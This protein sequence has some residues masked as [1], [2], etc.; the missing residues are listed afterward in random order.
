MESTIASPASNRPRN[1]V[2][3]IAALAILVVT[4]T[5]CD[6]AAVLAA[7]SIS[8]TISILVVD[9]LADAGVVTPS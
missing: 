1:R 8:Q 9:T 4:Q 5:G 7:N 3:G 6:F 2:A